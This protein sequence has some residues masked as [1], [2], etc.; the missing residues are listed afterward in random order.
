VA[1]SAVTAVADSESI[2]AAGSVW[3][4]AVPG[5]GRLT[6][7]AKGLTKASKTSKGRG[8]LT[9][10]LKAKGTHKLNTKVKLTFVRSRGKKL[11]ASASVR[12]R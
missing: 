7:T 10:T 11:T 5:A 2:R 4:V 1:L 8:I 12:V 9:L 3:K 6:A